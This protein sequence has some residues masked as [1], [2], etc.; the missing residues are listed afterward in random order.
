MIRGLDVSSVQY[1]PAWN[2][3]KASGID[4]AII[5]GQQGNDHLDP[6][7]ASNVR[8]AVESGMV[9]GT[10]HFVYPLSH[11]DPKWQA[12]KFFDATE[13]HGSQD[14]E[15]PPFLDCEWP[16]IQDWAKWKC[17]PQQVS[18]FLRDLCIAMEE[19]YCVK[20]VLY[21]YKYWWEYLSAHADVSWAE[22]YELWF[23][24]YLKGQWPGEGSKPPAL[25]PFKRALFWQWDGNGGLK[26]P[27]GRDADFCVFDGTMDE[28]LELTKR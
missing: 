14:G 8:G 6:Q 1:K 21:T 18:D 16:E 26:M 9:C 28:L 25:K 4:F 17:T 23:A 7:W 20:P 13:G 3:L 11:I 15:L 22:D 12:Q 10:Y 2:K 27:D 24:W 19:I 5:K